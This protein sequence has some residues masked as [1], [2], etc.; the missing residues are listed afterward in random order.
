MRTLDEFR[1]NH[2]TAPREVRPSVNL[3]M[4][5]QESVRA[6]A[7]TGDADWDHFLAYIEAVIKIA[8]KHLD[9]EVTKLRDPYRVNVDEIAKCKAAIT[10]LEAR[11]ATMTEV[12]LLPKFIKEQGEAAR[13]KIAEMTK[14]AA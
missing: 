8:T 12:I 9:I 11:I 5:A 1:R 4:I 7:V 6:A 10:A 13:A 3:Q 2:P 14:D